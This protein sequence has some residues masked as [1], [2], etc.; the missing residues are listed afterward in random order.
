MC[1]ESGVGWVF[2]GEVLKTL[3]AVR[4]HVCCCAHFMTIIVLWM[5]TLNV[6]VSTAVRHV[7]R[8]L[9]SMCYDRNGCALAAE[10]S[11]AV[12]GKVLEVLVGGGPLAAGCSP[13]CG[14]GAEIGSSR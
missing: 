4:L 1:G 7:S 6:C 5:M 10:S 12:S 9:K 3:G 14:W 2:L 11:R 13:R 8:C